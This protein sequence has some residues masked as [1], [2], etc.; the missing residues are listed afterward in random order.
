M[1]VH[2][3]L[4][5]IVFA[6]S[7]VQASMFPIDSTRNLKQPAARLSEECALSVDV[8][9]PLTKPF[10]SRCILKAYSPCRIYTENERTLKKGEVYSC[11]ILNHLSSIVINLRVFT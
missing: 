10:D 1:N 8:L 2:A 3:E 7:Q 5:V 6:R 11:R 9:R 4:Y